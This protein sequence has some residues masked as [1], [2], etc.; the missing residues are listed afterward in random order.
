MS[1]AQDSPD[2]LDPQE[3]P[4]SPVADGKDEKIE[5]DSTVAPTGDAGKSSSN[6]FF[7]RKSLDQRK[8]KPKPV[9]YQIHL[10][11]RCKAIEGEDGDMG[12]WS[13]LIVQKPQDNVFLEGL[14][15]V[16]MLS[17]EEECGTHVRIRLEGVLHC[18][19]WVVA[20]VNPTL[21]STVDLTFVTNDVLVKNTLQEWLPKWKKNG[22]RLTRETGQSV[23][24]KRPNSDLLE[25]IAEISTKIKLAVSWQSENSHEMVLVSDKVDG[26]LTV[27]AAARKEKL[28]A[29]KVG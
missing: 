23:G 11:I 5:T 10:C 25:E 29:E 28:E 27:L 3:S 12:A 7:N 17:G 14:Q 22:F 2:T 1:S 6:V 9:V 15:N 4:D 21:Y 20:N 24:E 18:L 13:A 16:V 8:K 26:M 19:K